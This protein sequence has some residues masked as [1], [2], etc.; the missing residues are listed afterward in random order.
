MFKTKAPDKAKIADRMRQFAK[1]EGEFNIS[2]EI[3]QAIDSWYI[4]FDKQANEGIKDDTGFVSRV[5]DFVMK[6]SMIVSTGRRGDKEIKLEDVK[7]AMDVVLPLIVPTKRVVNSVKKNDNT[8]VS[9]RA[10]ILTF[11]SSC[12]GYKCEKT[13]LLQNLGLQIDHED[14]DKISQFMIQMNVLK[15]DNQGPNT[16]YCLKVER[17]EVKTWLEQYR[18]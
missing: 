4:A 18:G 9:K 7:E 10:L 17:P 2:P 8:L 13:K 3:R 14:L 11:L 5:L 16:Y 1:L 12:E 6:V 15:I